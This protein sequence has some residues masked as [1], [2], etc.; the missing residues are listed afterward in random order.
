MGEPNL[1]EAESP[2]APNA[3]S[4]RPPARPTS[5]P[6]TPPVSDSPRLPS[7]PPPQP[8]PRPW[9]VAVG[10]ASGLALAACLV[11]SLPAAFRVA[12]AGGSFVG[13][14]LAAAA[15]VLP[16]IALMM[17]LS[18]AAARGFRMVTGHGRERG[19]RSSATSLVATGAI[20]VGLFLPALMVVGAVLKEKTNHRGLGGGT[21][22]VLA[23]GAGVFFALVAARVMRAGRAL[24][25]RGAPPRLVAIGFAVLTVG[26]VLLVGFPLLRAEDSSSEGR[27]VAAALVD[28]LIFTVATAVAL[29][30]EIG[31]R[32]RELA[33]RAGLPAG[34]ALVTAG[35][36]WLS[37]SPALGGALRAGGGLAAAMVGGL[38]RWTDR[39]GDGVGSHFGGHDCDE[40][41]PR[42]HPGAEDPFGDGIDQNCDGVDGVAGVSGSA[43]N[44]PSDPT[45]PTA[46]T[47][48]TSSAAAAAPSPAPAGSSKSAGSKL[49]VVFVTLESVRAD[50]TSLYGYTKKTTPHLDALAEKGVVFE[51]AYAPSSEPR[52]ALMPFFSAQSFKD[53]PRDGRE[54]PTLLPDANTLAERM[55]S[56]GY[57]TTFVSAFTWLSRERGFD[58]G[59]DAFDEVFHDEHPERGTTGPLSVRAARAAIE[60]AD[61]DQK[62]LF[63]W[64]QLFDAHEQ[65]RKH[66]GFDFGKGKTAAYDSEIGFVDKQLGDI[67]ATLEKSKLAG[68]T[69]VVVHGSYGE[70]F[71]EHD[72][73]SHGK[74]LYDETTRVPLVIA[75]PGATARRV[76]TPA[77]STLD[78]VPTLLEIAGAPT[79]KTCGRSLLAALDGGE[80]T[81][82]PVVLRTTNRRAI[83]EYP[84]KL[85]AVERKKK[86]RLLLFDLGADPKE[87]KDV[88][89]SH[90]DDLRRLSG[91]LD[92]ATRD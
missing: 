63:V 52:R 26:P 47:A 89:E 30:F 27:V 68:R 25:D 2:A 15:V 4:A 43:T 77:V 62:P 9:R 55:K 23:L 7:A 50:H 54:W 82:A 39:D 87:Q 74:E 71:G 61:P 18:R 6:P 64:V 19:A 51:H 75:M 83:V 78:I 1:D 20:F 24:V 32:A 56:A 46:P 92:A 88:S 29:T 49:S 35:F 38:E 53:T 13:G 60:S 31:E 40:G 5:E 58:Q 33:R 12:R 73:K 90:A 37:M 80:L 36:L 21:F 42:R 86:D 48:K 66:D 3:E 85:I 14:W 65:F 84:F 8:E 34:A 59:F 45:P 70:E 17:S 81:P 76:S 11:G 41:D 67:L 57:R 22:A 10:E 69:I 72:G 79:E 28:G 16:L 91:L 44:A